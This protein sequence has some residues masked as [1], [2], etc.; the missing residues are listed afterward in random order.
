MTG[1][2]ALLVRANFPQAGCRIM[3][4]GACMPD[5]RT[6]K[7]CEDFSPLQLD[8]DLADALALNDHTSRA[9]DVGPGTPVEV[10]SLD[11]FV[12]QRDVVLRR[13]QR[14]GKARP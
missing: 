7:Y 8:E 10:D 3:R 11:V 12:D 9:D 13:R 6:A 2:L 5:P 4:S 1:T 14:G